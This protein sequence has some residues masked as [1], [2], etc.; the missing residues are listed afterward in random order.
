MPQ[1]DPTPILGPGGA[2]ARRLHGSYESRPEQMMM[3]RGVARAIEEG[4]HLMVEA[5]TGVGKSFAYL[6]PAILAAAEAGKKVVVSTHTISLQEQLL[7]KDIPLLQAVMPQEFSAVLVKGRSN[8]LSL[9]RLGSATSRAGMTFGR[10]EEIDQ[11][12]EIQLWAGRTEDGSRSDLDFRPAPAV[13]DAVG[14]EHGNCLGRKCPK[15]R[16]CF[17][18]AARQRAKS[19]NILI[20]NH[21]LFMSDL[22][23]R[24]SGASLLPEY[25]VAIFDEAHTLE[26]V[27]G[28]HLGLRVTSTQVEFALGRLWNDRTRKGL[29]IYHGLDDAVEQARRAQFASADFFA[30]VS[31]WQ[32]AKGSS[33]GRL[34]R[35][36]GL[37]DILGEELRKLA[38]A[39]DRGA[40][41]IEEE[42]QRI[43]LAAASER[44][45][46]LAGSLSSWLAQDVADSVY[47]VEQELGPR[48]RLTLACAPLDIGPTLRR[49]LFDR[50]PTCILTSA[51]LSVGSP[52]GFSFAKARVGLLK[53]ETL[54]LGSPFDYP[55]QV[56]IH[57]PRNLPDPSDFPR[58]YEAAA[59]RAIPHYLAKTHGK[60]FVLFTSSKMLETAARALA[61]WFAER[62]IALYAQTDGMPRSKMV[63][64][65]KADV[66]SVIFGADSFWQGVDVP[67]EALSNVII[68]RL[69]FSVPDRP[70]LEARLEAIRARGG[71]PFV[72]YQV[73]EAV[74]KLKQGFG[75]LIRSKG[76]KGIV[77]ILDPRVLSKPY[78]RTFLAS[79]PDCPRVIEVL[80]I[81]PAG[82]RRPG[83]GGILED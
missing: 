4:S 47:W 48:R 69:P 77:A 63:E 34:R 38:S 43:E 1:F 80:S 16:Q 15:Y 46:A 2:I 33:N 25:D 14:S 50:V 58:D 59:I 35:P 70:L 72:D 22:A 24:G 31:H 20:V 3:A 71:S 32:G 65:F 83:R 52:P 67:G 23:L 61:P 5:G 27:A 62:N 79:L 7:G 74:L 56:A 68:V 51:T 60:A 40:G 6:V 18:F 78:G 26:G 29:L 19:A 53:C 37:P 49:D 13:W 42:D 64:A 54:Q 8:Y 73:P 66:D 36:S 9:R 21:A 12:A 17:Y 57:I 41:E 76:D 75:R 30:A 45:E 55:N 28:D 81:P 39:I 11:L 10:P 82:A 44:C